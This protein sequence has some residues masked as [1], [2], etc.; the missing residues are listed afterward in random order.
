MTLLL[1]EPSPVEQ[2]RQLEEALL[3]FQGRKRTPEDARRV[4]VL[5]LLEDTAKPLCWENLR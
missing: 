5:D 1:A 4:S 3:R 2:Q